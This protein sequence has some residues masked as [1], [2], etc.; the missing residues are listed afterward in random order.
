MSGFEIT[1]EQKDS[2]SNY[3]RL[4]IN[5]EI[6]QDNTVKITQS[7]LINGNI[8]NQ[9]E[10]HK[11]A[12]EIFSE[13]KIIPIVFSLQVDNID[14]DWV[15]NKMKEFGIKQKDLLKQLAID[16][17]SLNLVLSGKANLS[18][19]MKVGFFYY[20][21]TYELNRDLRT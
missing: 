6:L 4:G 20:F 1:T 13:H 10:L 18:R 3:K 9:K 15:K 12:R 7:R 8:L 11:R 21:L 17:T 5:I 16:K 14:L 19:L 2:I